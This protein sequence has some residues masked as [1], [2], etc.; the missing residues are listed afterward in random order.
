[1]AV[2]IAVCGPGECSPREE[3]WARQV[4]RL[5]AER[6]AVVLCGGYGGVMA[7]AAAGARAAGGTVV[8]L[9]SGADRQGACPDLTVVVPTGLGQARN[10][11]LVNSADAVIV[12]GGSWGT[13]SELA[14]A[15]RRGTPVVAL[16]GWRVIDA[17][18]GPVPGVRHAATP[19]EAVES[20]WPAA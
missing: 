2:Q 5:L 9:L 16:G 17:A 1:M 6:G 18:G 8:G 7:A 14:H 3:R 13:L 15:M 19:A 20:A 12:V 11:V 4:G 10:A